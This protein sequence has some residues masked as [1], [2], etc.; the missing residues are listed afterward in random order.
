MLN[1]HKKKLL[2]NIFFTFKEEKKREKGDLSNKERE[3]FPRKDIFK[4]SESNKINICVYI[5]KKL[6]LF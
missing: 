1:W 5:K 6:S 4:F 3:N 2:C